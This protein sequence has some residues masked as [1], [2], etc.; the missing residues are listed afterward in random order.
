MRRYTPRRASKR[1]LDE[2]CPAGVLAIFDHPKFADRYTVFYTDAVEVHGEIWVG[3][4]GMSEMPSHPQ[5]VG[6][7]N[8]MKA[9][10]VS[11]YR[12]LNY[13]R[14]CKWSSLPEKVKD[15]VRR[16]LTPDQGTP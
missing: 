6:M 4:R 3:Y 7:Y 2:D 8:E 15:C 9:Y 14:S 10:Q 12:T 1:W 11:I 16:D 5:G 13:H